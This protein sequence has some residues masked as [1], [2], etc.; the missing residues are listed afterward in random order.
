MSRQHISILMIL[1][2]LLV[3]VSVRSQQKVNQFR[4]L[5]EELPTP[6]DCRTASGAPGP[7]Y[8]QQ[9]ADYDMAVTLDERNRRI[10]GAETITYHNRSPHALSYL[11]VQL[12]QNMR[13]KDSDTQK[14]QIGGIPDRTSFR[15]LKRLHSDFDG[16]FKITSVTDKAG[17]DLPH[18]VVNTMMRVD[19][20]RPL[21]PK[22]SVTLKIAWWYNINDK[23]TIGG[24][25][26]YEYFEEDGNAIYAIAQFF[27]RMAVYSDAVGWHHKQ[28]LGGSEFALPFGDYRVRITVPADHIVG[29]TGALQNPADVLTSGQRAR[30]REAKKRTDKPVLIVTE[31][32]AR[33]NE[34]S[35]STVTKTWV[36]EAENVRDF[37]FASSRK[38]I[39]DAMGVPFGDRTALAMSFYPKEGNPLWERFSTQAVAHTLRI[40]SKYTFDYPYPVAI[41]VNVGGGGGMEY[42]MISF[43]GGR[44]EPDGTYS[45]RAKWG[46]IGLVIHEVGHNWFPMTVNSDERQWAWM[47]EGFNTFVEYLAEQEWD[48]DF[49]FRDGP[50]PAVINYMKGDKARISP[51]MTDAESIFQ[52]S[53]NAYNKTATGL[54]IL[55]ETIMGREL[56]DFAFKTYAR[57]WMFKHPEPADFFRTMEDASAMDL[58]WFW[59]G[60]FYGTNHVDIALDDVRWF[61]LDTGNP[62]VE[63]ANKKNEAEALPR[64]ITDIRNDSLLAETLA[65][66]NPS[67]RDFYD[68]YNPYD[69]TER[70]R[71]AYTA[72]L[73]SLADEEKAL[74]EKDC[75]YY[76]V[77][78]KNLGGMVMPLIV[79]LQFTDGTREIHRIPAEIWRKYN[80]AVTRIFITDKE[81]K[82][83]RLDPFIET[84]DVDTRNNVWTLRGSPKRISVI[85]RERKAAENP[86]QHHRQ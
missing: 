43:N 68:T 59:R 33:E 66:A 55:R 35:R 1:A 72:Y 78:F 38:F 77:H 71:E 75:N 58:D 22:S 40:Y 8:W 31:G 74:L 14:T 6:N 17:R 34:A 37:A 24:R 50:A 5:R 63:K 15:M 25:S 11:W 36:F 60:W 51:I 12:D 79:E 69:V 76:E 18:T 70:D 28:F 42:P 23:A 20:P 26:G 73:S 32:E 27:P 81:V 48:R 86:M 29:A 16:G 13:A 61:R 85:K 83:I 10:T 65:E 62:D 82:T 67:V 9:R 3:S 30:L 7:A 19:L 54:N 46:I 56:F 64:Y 57:R 41:S 45:Q 52:V 21:R 53:N 47:D 49:V 80:D 4:Q 2:L 84:A 44:P 39:W